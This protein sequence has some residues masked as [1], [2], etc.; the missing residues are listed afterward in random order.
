MRMVDERQPRRSTCP[1][2]AA[3]EI[4]G[5]RWSLLVVRNLM[6]GGARRYSDLL[7]TPEG[8]A[9][10]ILARRLADLQR[11]GIITA[12]P[13]PEDGRSRTYHLTEKGVALA[14][15]LLELGRWGIAYEDGEPPPGLHAAFDADR[16][17]FMAGLRRQL[18]DD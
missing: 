17:G 6:F 18:L 12:R 5:D 14:P 9:T 4:L 8:I 11:A 15:V 7:A 10:N 3:L 13:D 1:V 16:D 2:N